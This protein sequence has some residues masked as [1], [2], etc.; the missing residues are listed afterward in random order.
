MK[1]IGIPA[2]PYLDGIFCMFILDLEFKCQSYILSR[3]HQ[4]TSYLSSRIAFLLL[5]YWNISVSVLKQTA[6]HSQ[7]RTCFSSPFRPHFCTESSP[8]LRFLCEIP[9][10]VLPSPTVLSEAPSVLL[11][12]L[13]SVGQ[14][15]WEEVFVWWS[16]L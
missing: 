14:L 1:F 4:T 13:S 9:R 6:L 15:L 11:P 2:F 12:F 3:E 8:R 5:F 7:H 10:L 16:S